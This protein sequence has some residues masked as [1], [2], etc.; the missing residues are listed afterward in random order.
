MRPLISVDEQ[1]NPII[2]PETRAIP[3][4]KEIIRRDKTR[5][6]SKC[7]QEFSYIYHMCSFSSYCE[8]LPEEER[9]AEAGRASGLGEKYKPDKVVEE[10]MDFYER[11]QDTRSLRLLRSAYRTADELE[12]YYRSVD[13]TM[14]DKSGKPIYD[15]IKVMS[16]VKELG[17]F[18][19]KLKA[20]E[21]QVK[22]ELSQSSGV[23]GGHDKHLF[24]DPD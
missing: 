14:K 6:K 16:S 20:L 2:N 3:V 1:G 18:I 5:G 7:M 9:H 19:D 21:E 13:F 8:E 4:F 10:A 22:A 12:E 11:A 15:A 24:E 17:T 23:A